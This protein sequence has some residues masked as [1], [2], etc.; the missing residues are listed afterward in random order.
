VGDV[1]EFDKAV[2]I[3]RAMPIGSAV[4][5]G[6]SSPAGRPRAG[7]P[8]DAVRAAT[9]TYL[10]GEPL[11]MS[12]LA[13]ELGIGRATLYRWVGN[14]EEL[15]ATVLAA[16][17]ERTFRAAIKDADGEGVSLLLDCMRRFM[18]SVLLTPALKALIHREPLLFLRLATMPG[19]I[20]GKA[21]E[22][23]GELL[24]QE[25]ATGRLRLML[26]VP[27]M[28]EAIIRICDSHLYAHLLGRNEPE[29]ET[30]LQLVNLLL[31]ATNEAP[32]GS[33][34][35]ARDPRRVGGGR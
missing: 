14:R 33:T 12:A 21:A 8:E 28:A 27:V 7:G 3:G 30:A 15:L 26:P 11:D 32:A 35:T 17:T 22:L 31:R 19:A 25:A 18:N 5:I 29:V 23:V 6:A 1:D 2:P 24:E 9:R 34:S 4:P 10:R 13:A 20:E 16:G